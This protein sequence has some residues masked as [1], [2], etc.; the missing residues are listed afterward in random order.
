MSTIKLS[1]SYCYKNYTLICQY[2]Q[3]I[4]RLWLPIRV[5]LY[6]RVELHVTNYFN[7]FE[8]LCDI[9]ELLATLIKI[10]V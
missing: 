3:S 8:G 1:K 5:D 9:I 7:N 2:G 6:Q 10:Y 4:K